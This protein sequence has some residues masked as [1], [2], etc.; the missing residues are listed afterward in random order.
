MPTGA[1]TS[2]GPSCSGSTAPPGSREEALAEHLHRLEEA[3]RR[4]HRRLG[5]ELDLFSFPD[6]IGSGL[7]VFHPKGGLVRRMMEDYSRARHEQAGYEFVNT[8][9]IT[10]V[11]AVR[12]LRAPA[13][14]RRGACSR[15]WSSTRGS[16][17]T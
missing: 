11:G 7:A 5:L 1:A 9:H 17:T 4:D 12:D 6:E 8:P 15:R 13:V 2:T 16:A 3:E 14:V 10:Q